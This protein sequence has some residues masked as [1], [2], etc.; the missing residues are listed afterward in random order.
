MAS[1]KTSTQGGSSTDQVKVSIKIMVDTKA[2]KVVFAE[3]DKDFVDF[4]FHILTLPL[5]TVVK[6]LNQKGMAGCLSDLYKSIESLNTNYFE[7]NRDKDSVL[8]PRTGVIAPLLALNDVPN[9]VT[10]YLCVNHRCIS[11]YQG[12]ACQ[13]VYCYGAVMPELK[14]TYI[15][16]KIS[17]T[18]TYVKGQVN[19]MVTDNLEV[20]P[21][22][23]SLIKSYVEDFDSLGLAILKASLETSEVLTTVFLG[24]KIK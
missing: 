18:N 4:I 17:C 5:S 23:V 9:I 21:M 24:K 1:A 12:T 22:S 7:A 10:H 11:D 16:P 19:Y 6:L 13:S 2:N 8:K 15:A 14:L 3:A 20:K